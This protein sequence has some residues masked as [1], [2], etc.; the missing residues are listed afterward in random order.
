MSDKLLVAC[1]KPVVLIVHSMLSVSLASVNVRPAPTEML[2]N[3]N[4]LLALFCLYMPVPVPRLVPEK[5]VDGTD[6]SITNADPLSVMVRLVPAT[7]L[8]SSSADPVA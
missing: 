5:L 4:S 3:S 6:A 7:R 2:L 1:K 8:L